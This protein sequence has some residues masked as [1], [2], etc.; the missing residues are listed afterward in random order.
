MA[1]SVTH[2]LKK[3][4]G[5]VEYIT[6]A[7]INQMVA[8]LTSSITGTLGTSGLDAGAVTA[9]KSTPGAYWYATAT[10]TADALLLTLSPAL[11]SLAS[12]ATVRFKAASTN[13]GAATIDVNGLGVKALEKLAGDA[14]V[15]GDLLANGIYEATYDGA[16]WLVAVV[17]GVTTAQMT[18]GAVTAVKS[19]PGAYWYGVAAGTAD[20]LTLT[21]VPPLA[22]LDEGATVRFKAAYTNTGAATL[23]VDGLGVKDLDRQAADPLGAGEIAAGAIYEAI[24]DGTQWEIVSNLHR[25]TATA[26]LDFPSTSGSSSSDLT[27]A[28]TGAVVGDVCSLGVPVSA[29]SADTSFSVF[30]SATDVVTVRFNNYSSGAENPASAT[31]RVVIDKF[32]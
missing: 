22:A 23:N 30:V 19:T 21:L 25:L 24:Y 28:V 13:T 32:A 10:G 27:I 3:L 2:V 14:L 11:A 6:P 16:Q 9:A 7:K 17:S 29:V 20:A 15:A 31:F 5:P 8:S 26:V 4:L 18:D 12:G 1:L